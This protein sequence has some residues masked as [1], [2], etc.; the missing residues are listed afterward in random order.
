MSGCK[1]IDPPEL[2]NFR[3]VIPLTWRP[4]LLSSPRRTSLFRRSR[5]SSSVRL[6]TRHVDLHQSPIVPQTPTQVRVRRIFF[7]GEKK[8]GLVS[9]LAHGV[10]LS[11]CGFS[12]VANFGTVSEQPL[13]S[14]NIQP[15]FACSRRRRIHFGCV[16]IL[17]LD[18][19]HKMPAARRSLKLTFGANWNR[20]DMYTHKI[21]G[22]SAV[23]S[24]GGRA[25]VVSYHAPPPTRSPSWAGSLRT[26]Y[27]I[28]S[29]RVAAGLAIAA[30]D[31][32]ICKASLVVHYG[33]L[34]APGPLRPP[35][36]ARAPSRAAR[37]FRR[38][39]AS[40]S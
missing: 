1:I 36:Q 16:A 17:S 9:R 11:W 19:L 33:L 14:Y 12:S 18:A 22:W 27:R 31:A 7:D 6:R 29:P 26:D 25:G 2:V 30:Q 21:D 40:C 37:F 38:N 34:G 20:R 4:T 5:P 39:A 32:G 24:R 3:I 10:T 15:T 13:P 8:F 28:C 35:G 23:L